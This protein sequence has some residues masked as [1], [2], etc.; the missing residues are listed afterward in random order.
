MMKKRILIF[1]YSGSIHIK[2]WAVNL[3]ERGYTVRVVS[4]EGDDISEVEV[5]RFKRFG[6]LSYFKH[7]A[8]AAK[9][10]REFKPDIVHVHYAGG[11]GIWGVKTKFHPLVVSVWGSDIE[12]LP[13]SLFYRPFIKSILS[14]ADAITATSESLK[15]STLNVLESS[16]VKI[17]VIPFGVPLP[18]TKTEF[19][20]TDNISVIYLKHLESIYA[21]DILIKAVALVREKF[22]TFK[23]TMCG[24][25]SLKK[26]LVQ[27]VQELKLGENIHFAGYVDNSKIYD[28]IKQHHFMVMPSLQE[29]F[30]VAAVEAFACSRPVVATNVGGI[31][32]IV[33]DGYNG[34]LVRPNNIQ[35]L[36]DTMLKIIS[37][38]ERM[39][40]MGSNGY[41]TA[42]Q[43]FDWG[44]SV[45]K[46]EELYENCSSGINA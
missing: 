18:K 42:R 33:T 12:S 5:I 20:K 35:E 30:G 13:K 40:Q 2:K 4:L 23:L 17:D 44:K 31:P 26:R 28:L 15:K 8:K 22:P 41:E 11:Y 45:D 7:A 25:G 38:K 34:Y 3:A 37:D 32:E 16:E 24:A 1:G 36:A 10:A 21:P 14:H 29:G 39:I 46:M 43:N 6:K 19:P 27:L 9:T